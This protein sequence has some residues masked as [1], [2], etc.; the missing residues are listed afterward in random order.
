MVKEIQTINCKEFGETIAQ[1]LID[2][3]GDDLNIDHVTEEVTYALHEGIKAD[4][5]YFAYNYLEDKGFD[6]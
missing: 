1:E 4:I 5:L 3:Y 2:E 6:I